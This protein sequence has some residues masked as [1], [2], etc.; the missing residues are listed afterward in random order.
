M[1]TIQINDTT[2]EV[3]G[4]RYT[5]GERYCYFGNNM[6]AVLEKI[7]EGSEDDFERL[8]VGNVYPPQFELWVEDLVARGKANWHATHGKRKVSMSEVEEKFGEPVEIIEE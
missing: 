1:T 7:W 5:R 4:V 6:S 3:D 8:A 2:V